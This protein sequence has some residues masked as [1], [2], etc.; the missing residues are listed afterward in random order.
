VL[1]TCWVLYATFKF[2]WG[3]LENSW[4]LPAVGVVSAVV[5]GLLLGRILK[6]SSPRRCCWPFPTSGASA[7]NARRQW[8]DRV[9]GC[10]RRNPPT[11]REYLTNEVRIRGLHGDSRCYVKRERAYWA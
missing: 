9:R 6:R 7:A 5:Q 8:P 11:R 3:P 2:G 10:D 1:Y 4:S